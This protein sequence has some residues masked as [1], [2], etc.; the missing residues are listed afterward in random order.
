MI[1]LWK[2]IVTWLIYSLAS[3]LYEHFFGN[4]GHARIKRTSSLE[5]DKATPPAFSVGSPS[6]HHRPASKML[7]K[8]RFTDGSM[9]AALYIEYRFSYKY[10]YG[11]PLACDPSVKQVDD[12]Q[13]KRCW[14][15]GPKQ[16]KM[17]HSRSVQFVVINSMLQFYIR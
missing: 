10:G 15:F 12:Y 4:H 7:C 3:N 8:C 17:E 2:K 1:L 16:P 14:N 5:N 6:G 13:H 11:P 9:V